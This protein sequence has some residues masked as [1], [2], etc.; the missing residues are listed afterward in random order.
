MRLHGKMLTIAGQLPYVY[1]V[2]QVLFAAGFPYQFDFCS[3]RSR[4]RPFIYMTETCFCAEWRKYVYTPL[5]THVNLR[6]LYQHAG[7][8]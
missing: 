8:F 4:Q 2:W 7:I 3:N 5:F 6:M 1:V